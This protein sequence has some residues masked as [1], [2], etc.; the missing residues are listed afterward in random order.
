MKEILVTGG[1]GYIGSHTVVQL[2]EN[3]YKP[4]IVDNLCNSSKIAIERVE[5]I[6]GTSIAFYEAETAM[7]T[8]DLTARTTSF[9]WE[10]NNNVSASSGQAFG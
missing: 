9:E 2:I 6:T 1:M 3:N 7:G 4:V 8:D 10:F 5:K